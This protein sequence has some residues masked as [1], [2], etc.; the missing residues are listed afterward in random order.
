[1]PHIS[2]KC[3]LYVGESIK[4]NGS[5]GSLKITCLLLTGIQKLTQRQENIYIFVSIILLNSHHP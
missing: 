5:N 3:K 2:Y 1:M 4:K